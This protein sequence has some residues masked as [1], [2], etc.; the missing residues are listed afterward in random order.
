MGRCMPMEIFGCVRK[1]QAPL[2]DYFP[3]DFITQILY[4]GRIVDSYEWSFDLKP[5]K[6]VG[7]QELINAAEQLSKQS[8]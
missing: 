8:N 5:Q 4:P 6:E 2:N 3:F 1:L 7:R